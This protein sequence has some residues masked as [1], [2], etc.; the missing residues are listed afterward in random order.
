[1][2]GSATS[3]GALSFVHLAR[4]NSSTHNRRKSF[5]PF[6]YSYSA[7]LHGPEE[8]DGEL[9]YAG[10]EHLFFETFSHVGCPTISLDHASAFVH[11]RMIVG[12]VAQPP[13][14]YDFLPRSTQSPAWMLSALRAGRG[15]QS[16]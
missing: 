14:A 11:Y 1:M 4:D 3:R 16:L 8:D 13:G 9:H 12:L 7:L 15:D 6:S 10:V 5:L 2:L